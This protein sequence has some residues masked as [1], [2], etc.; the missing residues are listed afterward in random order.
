MKV[1]ER[2]GIKSSHLTRKIKRLVAAPGA[3]KRGDRTKIR[4]KFGVSE[5]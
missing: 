1:L 2:N 3:V 5:K 4:G